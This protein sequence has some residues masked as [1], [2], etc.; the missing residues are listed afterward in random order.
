MFCSH[1]GQL[2]QQIVG[3]TATWSP[4]FNSLAFCAFEPISTTV[5]ENSWPKPTG[6]DSL[7]TGCGCSFD[8][9]KVGVEYSWRSVPQMPTKAGALYMRVS[10]R[11]GV[12]RQ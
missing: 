4:T 8:G 2:K 10:W 9:M 3:C 5:P 1:D 12:G 11:G 6:I 7:V